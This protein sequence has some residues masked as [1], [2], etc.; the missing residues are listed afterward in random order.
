M[1]LPFGDLRVRGRRRDER[2]E[3][4]GPQRL[5][6]DLTVLAR[7][8]V[9]FVEG[10]TEADPV[11]SPED[12]EAP[13]FESLVVGNGRDDADD[14]PEVGVA[15][16]LRAHLGDRTPGGDRVEHRIGE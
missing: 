1:L 5:R 4:F 15:R 12:E 3:Q 16:R 2:E 10:L 6:I 11:V 9:G 13:R 14:L 7:D 8:T